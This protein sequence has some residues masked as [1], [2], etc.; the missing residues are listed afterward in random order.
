MLRAADTY[1]YVVEALLIAI[2]LPKKK[3]VYIHIR[4]TS[5]PRHL[6]TWG[7]HSRTLSYLYIELQSDGDAYQVITPIFRTDCIWRRRKRSMAEP[8]RGTQRAAKRHEELP[9]AILQQ[10]EA[11]RIYDT[12]SS[13]LVEK[14]VDAYRV[15]L[16]EKIFFPAFPFQASVSIP[17]F[18]SLCPT[19]SARCPC[20]CLAFVTSQS[21]V[22]GALNCIIPLWCRYSSFLWSM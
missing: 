22:L 3:D 21:I 9:D 5:P 2:Y 11:I 7:L 17:G 14:E 20:P 6:A 4:S 18:R 13:H 10:R 8:E 16:D 1:A 19:I 15:R 12:R